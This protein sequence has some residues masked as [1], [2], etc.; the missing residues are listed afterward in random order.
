[1][2]HRWLGVVTCLVLGSACRDP[3]TP[4]AGTTASNPFVGARFYLNPDYTKEVETAAAAAGADAAKLRKVAAQPT[5]I[6]LDSIAK[7]QTVA[8][9]LDDAEKKQAEGTQPIL[10][11][12][13]VYNLPNRDCSA[14]SSAG[15]LEV[16]KGGEARYKTEFIDVI[17]AQFAAHPKQRIVAVIEPDSLPNIATNL[18]VPKCAASE[19]AYRHSIAYAISKLS[20]PHVS[21][22]LDAAHAGWLGWD[23]NRTRIAAIFKDVLTEAGGVGKIRGFATNVSNYN[24][25]HGDDGKTLEPSNP[26]PDEATYVEQLADSLEDVG[27]KGKGFIIDTSRDGRAGIR[28]KW[29][30]W[31]NVK[32]AGLGERPRAAPSKHIDAFFWVKPP[33]E[34]DGTSN[35]SAARFDAM[36]KGPDAAP[37]APQAGDWFSAYF[38]ELVRNANP[39]L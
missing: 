26:C 24:V 13:A 39:P 18:S 12:F 10:S 16:E 14:K 11:L 2:A 33:G 32:G 9:Y 31:C 19:Q 23:G 34:S 38:Q 28:S 37:D 21:L 1:M 17:A 3:A 5:A 7:A 35:D 4:D 36:C 20:M 22:Y 29:G 27:I 8:K 30:S 15:E 6:W 25:V